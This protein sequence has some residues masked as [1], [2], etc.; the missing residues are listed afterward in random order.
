MGHDRLFEIFLRMLEETN[1]LAEEA[2]TLIRRVVDQYCFELQNCG[3]IPQ[4]HLHELIADLEAE[5]VEMYR[6]KT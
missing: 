2:S 5:V 6:K 4:A 1:N 3:E